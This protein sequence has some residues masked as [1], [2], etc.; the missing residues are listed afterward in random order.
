MAKPAPFALALL[1]L[2]LPA[3]AHAQSF[4]D[5]FN[6]A[7][8]DTS[9]WSVD[10]GTGQVIVGG[11]VVTLTGAGA[12]F[13][14]VTTRADPFPPGDFRLRV[15]MQYLSQGFCGDGFGAM[16]NFWEDYYTGTACRP[17]L[18]WQDSGGEYVYSGGAG[19]TVIAPPPEL[20]YHVYEWD[21]LA[22]QYQFLVDGVFRAS[23]AC[24]P[25]ATSI[26]FG[27]PHPIGCG[28]PWS[29]F[30]IDF[31]DI[32]PLGATPARGASWGSVKAKYR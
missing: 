23:G 28:G 12:T 24:A 16:D 30:A 29:S 20:G 9:I 7:A 32:A 3:I 15:G 2:T 11:G 5:D 4:H 27:H 22:G 18:L 14:V 21:Y 26:F 25:R 6:G 13:P 10:L 17:F 31:I 19:G 8:L 1:L